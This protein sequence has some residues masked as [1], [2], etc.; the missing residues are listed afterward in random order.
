MHY[1]ISRHIS[2][3]QVFYFYNFIMH[4]IFFFIHLSMTSYLFP[5]IYFITPNLHCNWILLPPLLPSVSLQ[6][7]YNDILLSIYLSISLSL[8]LNL[9]FPFSVY[10]SLT[11]SLSLSLTFAHIRLS[12][13]VMYNDV[14][15]PCLVEVGSRCHGGEGTWLPTIQECI[16]FTQVSVTL[17]V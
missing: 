14:T 9:S 2:L 3:F 7:M 8:F 15:G 4:D 10:L 1:F 17:Y 5:L 13:Q 11:L 6:V 16:G 12:S